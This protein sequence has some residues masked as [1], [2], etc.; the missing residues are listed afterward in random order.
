M[1]LSSV[2]ITSESTVYIDTNSKSQ[3][4]CKNDDALAKT[5][6]VTVKT[7]D[8]ER[9]KTAEDLEQKCLHSIRTVLRNGALE[10]QDLIAFIGK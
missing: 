2:L 7:A 5:V 3:Y 9:M 8:G 6:T 1:L 10:T 4:Y